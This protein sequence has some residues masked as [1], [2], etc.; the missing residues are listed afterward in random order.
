MVYPV[1]SGDVQAGNCSRV[2]GFHRSEDFHRFDHHERLIGAN[3][4]AHF[5]QYV[6]D[7]A[8]HWGDELAGLL[9]PFD[10][11]ARRVRRKLINIAFE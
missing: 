7:G 5:D 1:S 9:G 4:L 6:N 11:P 8:G 10:L 3:H 2:M